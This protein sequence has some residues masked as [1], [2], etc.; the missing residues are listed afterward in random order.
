MDRKLTSRLG[1]LK[2]TKIFLCD[3]HLSI[4]SYAQNNQMYDDYE[5]LT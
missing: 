1:T 4:R 2:K 3:G 5:K